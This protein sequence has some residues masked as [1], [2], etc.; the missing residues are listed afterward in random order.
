M[1][2]HHRQCLLFKGML[3]GS[4]IAASSC[5]SRYPIDV[6]R[7]SEIYKSNSYDIGLADKETHVVILGPSVALIK[8]IS[9]DA[10]IL[11]NLK[12]QELIQNPNSRGHVYWEGRDSSTE[13]GYFLH[14]CGSTPQLIPLGMDREKAI[15]LALELVEETKKGQG[16]QKEAD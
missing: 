15:A 4:V 8:A 2:K 12:S 1:L 11:S 9:R 14:Q 10:V 5:S 13:E 6:C 16:V 3:L 7:C